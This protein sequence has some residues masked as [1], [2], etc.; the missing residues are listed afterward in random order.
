MLAVHKQ[1]GSA[2]F[3]FRSLISTAPDLGDD[4]RLARGKVPLESFAI[5]RS[6][7]FPSVVVN[8]DKIKEAPIHV[9]GGRSC[10]GHTAMKDVP[11]ILIG[12]SQEGVQRFVAR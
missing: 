12:S 9:F 10:I 1:K 4:D 2:A 6:V 11:D 7:P 5:G 3:L 8:A